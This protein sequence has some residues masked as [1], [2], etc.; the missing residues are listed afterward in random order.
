[1]AESSYL[2]V[3]LGALG[4]VLVA[5]AL[6][7]ALRVARPGARIGFLTSRECLPLLAQNPDLDQ[8][9]G[10][11]MSGSGPSLH[12]AALWRLRQAM[13]AWS[14]GTA[15]ILHRRPALALLCRMTGFRQLTG[16]ADAG[17]RWLTDAVPFD[18]RRHRMER[19][20][21][22]L[23]RLGVH[24]SARRMRLV[25]GRRERAWGESVWGQMPAHGLRLVLAPGGGKNR[26]SEM[27]NRRWPAVHFRDIALRAQKA[28]FAVQV[29]GGPGEQALARSIAEGAGAASHGAGVWSLRETAAVIAAA[30]L[31][32]SNDS[33]PLFLSAALQVPVV[34]LYGPT[35]SHLIHPPGAG[36]AL[37]GVV[38][39]GPCYTPSQGAHGMAYRCPRACCMETL[40]PDFVWSEIERW[41]PLPVPGRLA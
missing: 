1:M 12:P 40:S 13:Q 11:E 18:L 3:K 2:I 28:G 15:V 16:F 26:W 31:V 23:H 32:V 25:L 24:H 35:D 41:V 9:I 36:P 20:E 19:Q 4:D 10:V 30:H 22:L 7:R 33:L 37:Q 21:Q 6:A 14:E 27:P 34:G 17:N 29:I 39:C 8:T 38:A 5:T